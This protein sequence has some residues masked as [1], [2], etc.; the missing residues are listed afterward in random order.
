MFRQQ[1]TLLL[2]LLALLSANAHAGRETALLNPQ[3]VPVSTSSGKTP[4]AEQLRQSIVAAG[5]GKT[6]V[7]TPAGEGKMLGV[8]DVR[9]K[10]RLMVDIAY[11]PA[12]FHVTY[13]DSTNL[14]YGTD[15]EGVTVIHPNANRWMADF[16]NAIRQEILRR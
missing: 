15:L 13:R 12:S 14:N 16:S 3:P 11:S 9:G 1:H 2:L 4:T 6:W 8:I 10:H 5:T 7:V